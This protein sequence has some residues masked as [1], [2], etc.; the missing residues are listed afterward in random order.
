MQ[1]Y[2]ETS[3]TRWVWTTKAKGIRRPHRCGMRCVYYG[4]Q[5]VCPER[6]SSSAVVSRVA[7][8]MIWC[9]CLWDILAD[10]SRAGGMLLYFTL[11]YKEQGKCIQGLCVEKC[12]NLGLLCVLVVTAPFYEFATKMIQLPISQACNNCNHFLLFPLYT[13]FC[14]SNLKMVALI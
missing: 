7:W 9:R 5:L 1:C 13:V 12:M 6:I 8:A 2:L 4:W 11:K 3:D 10:S 14:C